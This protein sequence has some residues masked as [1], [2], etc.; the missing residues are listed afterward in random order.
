M[1]KDF[2]ANVHQ[3]VSNSSSW[4]QN[5]IA[6]LDVSLNRPHEPP[7]ATHRL[8]EVPA[9]RR[10]WRNNSA[11]AS[12]GVAEG[13]GGLGV[14]GWGSGLKPE[15]RPFELRPFGYGFVVLVGVYLVEARDHSL[16]CSCC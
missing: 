3:S 4:L 7:I 12:R 15:A 2:H 1:A 5:A 6:K 16:G 14:G 9:G 11:A 10:G 8:I 13:G